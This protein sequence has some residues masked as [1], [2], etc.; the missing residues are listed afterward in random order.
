M[1][2]KHHKVERVHRRTAQANKTVPHIHILQ[3]KHYLGHEEQNVDQGGP[4][5]VA[6]ASY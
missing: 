2:L 3:E 5:V 1:R 6:G 4:K